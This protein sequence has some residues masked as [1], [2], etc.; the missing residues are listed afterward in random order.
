MSYN[1]IINKL[2][3]IKRFGIT[4]KRI[5]QEIGISQPTLSNILTGHKKVSN[6]KIN[7]L[8]ELLDQIIDKCE[9]IE[10]FNAIYSRDTQKKTKDVSKLFRI[11]NYKCYH[12]D[13]KG[14]IKVSFITIQK[15]F[16]EIKMDLVFD[17]KEYSANNEK[18]SF[19]FREVESY[20]E[21]HFSNELKK[22][23]HLFITFS[24]FPINFS[25]GIIFYNKNHSPISSKIII[26]YI[27]QTRF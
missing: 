18:N 4:Q 21:I 9:N 19:I 1:Q 11:G 10:D 22:N 26:E 12:S 7:E 5:S 24:D 13:G 3:T 27:E 8:S 16:N 17:E 2:S 6:E 20:I 25:L 15:K 23:I 14:N